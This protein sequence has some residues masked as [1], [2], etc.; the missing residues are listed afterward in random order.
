MLQFFASFFIVIISTSAIAQERIAEKCVDG[1]IRVVTFSETKVYREKICY[2][3]N[4]VNFHSA[5]CKKQK[6]SAFKVQ[7]RYYI[8][9][10][11]GAIGT[12]GFKLCREMG[13]AP[14]IVEVFAEGLWHSTDRC[15]F[16]DGFVDTDT[17]LDFY[18]DRESSL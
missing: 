14:E 4:V 1:K 5:S 9:E 18:I 17:L 3:D 13:G 8:G 11:I 16:R 15:I 12:P 6:C 7:K 10:F 2:S